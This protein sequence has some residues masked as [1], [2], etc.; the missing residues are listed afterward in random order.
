MAPL[1]KPFSFGD[2]PSNSGESVGVQCSVTRGDLPITIH[3]L[4]ND[5]PLKSGDS[6]IIIGRMSTKSSTLNIDYIRAEHRGVYTCQAI[7]T[8][9]QNIFNAELKVNG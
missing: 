4:L 3:W 6:E 2:E 7:N 8:A 1:I 5:R 9:G